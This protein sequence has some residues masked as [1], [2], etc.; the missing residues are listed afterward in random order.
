MLIAFLDSGNRSS[1]GLHAALGLQTG[2]VDSA[3][4][5]IFLSQQDSGMENAMDK[6]KE[7]YLEHNFSTRK[8]CD[9]NR[10]DSTAKNL[11]Q[12]L[13]RIDFRI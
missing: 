11:V 1:G 7:N 3:E 8:P 10:K 5:S 4:D 13:S 6:G 2:Q 12:N 9:L